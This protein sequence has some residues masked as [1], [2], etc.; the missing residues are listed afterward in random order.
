VRLHK[1]KREYGSEINIA[2]LIDVVFLLIIFFLTVSHI[3]QV[4]VEALSLP[5]AKEADKSQHPASGRIIINVHKNGRIVVS[6]E[7]YETDSLELML[8][9][10]RENSS[11]G[12][13][14][15]L[16]RGDRETLWARVSEIMQVLTEL[17]I[18]QISIAVIEPGTSD[19][20]SRE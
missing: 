8:R 7:T 19:P 5:E 10:E 18:N 3:T 2:P 16:L 15:V 14:S 11:S 12:G 9:T 6:G 1:A 4:R 17:G 13:M 20:G